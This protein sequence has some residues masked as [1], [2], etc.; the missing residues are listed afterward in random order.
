MKLDEEIRHWCIAVLVDN[1]YD[2]FAAIRFLHDSLFLPR[3]V[4]RELRQ[5]VEPNE[6][7]NIWQQ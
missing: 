3:P 4:F 5:K 1:G 2:R 6:N 7:K